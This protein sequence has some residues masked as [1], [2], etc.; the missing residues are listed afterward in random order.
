VVGSRTRKIWSASK[1]RY[2]L[3]MSTISPSKS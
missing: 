1:M 3:T 2:D